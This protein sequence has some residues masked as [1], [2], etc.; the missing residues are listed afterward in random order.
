MNLLHIPSSHISSTPPSFPPSLHPLVPPSLTLS[1]TP[2]LVL[3]SSHP[4]TIFPLFPLSQT[5][6]RKTQTFSPQPIPS[7]SHLSLS[8]LRLPCLSQSPLFLFRFV[9]PILTVPRSLSGIRLFLALSPPPPPPP[10]LS[11]A[12]R[13]VFLGRAKFMTTPKVIR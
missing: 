13:T 1:D 10:S 9:P 5:P 6:S 4:P 12:W 8:P 2:S 7:S 3:I 11:C